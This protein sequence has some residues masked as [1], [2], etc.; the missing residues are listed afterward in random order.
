MK[1][2]SPLAAPILQEATNEKI[3]DTLRV[4]EREA[5]SEVVKNSDNHD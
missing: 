3:E 1:L 5:I 4:E 2:F